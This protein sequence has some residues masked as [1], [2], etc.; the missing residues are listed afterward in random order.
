MASNDLNLTRICFGS[1]LKRPSA[2]SVVCSDSQAHVRTFQNSRGAFSAGHGKYM[3]VMLALGRL[4]QQCYRKSKD[5]LNYIV[6]PCFRKKKKRKK[7]NKKAEVPY[8]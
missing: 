3:F 4:E 6:R 8:L 7:K 5:S 1:L 2:L